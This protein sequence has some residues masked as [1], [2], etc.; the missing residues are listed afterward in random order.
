MQTNCAILGAFGLAALL[1]GLYALV[2][3]DANNNGELGPGRMVGSKARRFGFALV[4]IGAATCAYS[5][6]Q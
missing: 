5:I 6:F 1:W 3:E 2:T 4:A